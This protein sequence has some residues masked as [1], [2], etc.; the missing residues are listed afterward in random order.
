MLDPSEVAAAVAALLARD[1]SGVVQTIT[2][3]AGVRPVDIA[4]VLG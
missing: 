3:E 1:D 4:T 2:K